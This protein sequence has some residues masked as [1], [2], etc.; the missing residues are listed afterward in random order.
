[1]GEKDRR[2][3][4]KGGEE[5]EREGKEKRIDFK[6]VEREDYRGIISIILV[7][8]AVVVGAVTAFTGNVEAFTAVMAVFGPLITLVVQDYFRSRE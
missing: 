6:S 7:C 8:G 4:V 5:K 2:I 1:M 3:V